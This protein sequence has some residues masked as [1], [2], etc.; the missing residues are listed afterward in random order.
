MAE[1]FIAILAGGSGTRLWPLSRAA[2]P[3]QV[4]DLVG[5]GSLLRN[6]FDRVRP[7]VP[8]DHVYILTE[9]SHAGDIR[10][11]LPEVPR[12][13]VLIEP[14]RRGTAGSLALA[15]LLIHRRAPDS[16]WASI[17]ADHFIQ[18]EDAF[19]ANLDAAFSGAAEM[20]Y[21]FTLGIRPTHPSTQL[22]YIH[23][24]EELR[25]IGELPVHRVGRFV[26]KPD[27][28]RAAE[29]V[30]SGEYFWN[31][32]YFFW[33]A[34][35]IVQQ[36]AN[37]LPQI[38]DPL[39]QLVDLFG[40]A[41]FQPRYEQVYPTIPIETIDTGI[42]ERAPHIAVIPATFGWSDIGSWKELYEAIEPDADGN[43]VRGEH[44]AIDSAGSL[45]FGGRR[46][47]A[48]IGVR[49]LVIVETDDVL[50]VCPRDRAAEVKMVVEQLEQQG[51]TELL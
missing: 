4:L 11:Q 29:F 39:A 6:T 42:M 41:S 22:G 40:T 25:Q 24:A 31:P 48:T 18:D 27:E 10:Q 30:A 3:K 19:R 49:D 28:Q 36:F 20:P 7:L 33:S 26:E 46:L 8:P 32:G 44:L 1:R 23:A 43:A 37:L 35:G 51:R 5:R 15:A 50:L 14:A 45:I 38:H 21:L 9:Q 34:E 12:D 16:V 13:N 2:R 17:H 47:V